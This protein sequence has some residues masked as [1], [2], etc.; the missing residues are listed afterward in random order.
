[1][2]S[3]AATQINR[4]EI[5]SARLEKWFDPVSNGFSSI[6]EPGFNPSGAGILGITAPGE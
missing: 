5:G 4:L 3:G 1:M 6:T 2:N